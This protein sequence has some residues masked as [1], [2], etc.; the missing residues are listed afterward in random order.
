[1]SLGMLLLIGLAIAVAVTAMRLS[2]RLVNKLSEERPLDG[3]SSN[4]A[5]LDKATTDKPPTDQGRQDDDPQ[6]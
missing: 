4:V 5:P 2:W 1:M 6:T 3:R